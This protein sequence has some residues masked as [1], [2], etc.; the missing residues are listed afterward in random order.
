MR[1]DKHIRRI[2]KTAMVD[3]GFYEDVGGVMMEMD[4]N[5]PAQSEFPHAC[6]W[7][8]EIWNDF[9]T[10][11]IIDEVAARFG[12]DSEDVLD[13][14]GTPKFAFFETPNRTHAGSSFMLDPLE[15]T[16]TMK[17]PFREWRADNKEEVLT[18][19]IHEFTH[20]AD[21]LSGTVGEPKYH[22]LERSERLR[23][24]FSNPDEQEAIQS[25]MLDLMRF[26]Y[27][28][29]QIVNYIISTIKMHEWIT[30]SDMLFFQTKLEETYDDLKE[31]RASEYVYES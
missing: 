9:L 23:A 1:I 12:M 8:R 4:F 20:G 26:G 2:L 16:L 6:R 22:G 5:N 17:I 15:M 11:P 13:L 7:A 24:W 30:H 28:K 21:M 14:I 25:Q 29:T 18:V 10:D 31:E 3:C 27:N 19:L